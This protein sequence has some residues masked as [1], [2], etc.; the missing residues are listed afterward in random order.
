ME[1]R[2]L[3]GPLPKAKVDLLV[4]GVF[5]DPSGDA[6]FKLLSTASKRLLRSVVKEQ[7]FV[8]KSTQSV[9]ALTEKILPAKYVAILG[10]GNESRFKISDLRDHAARATAIG[11]RLGARSVA[12]ALPLLPEEDHALATQQA[13]EGGVLGCYKFDK[14][15]TRDL[16]PNPIKRFGVISAPKGGKLTRA[17]STALSAAIKRGEATARATCRA[18]DFVNEHAGYMTPT[19]I[20]EEAKSLAKEHGLKIKVLGRREC[21][22]LGMGMYLAVAQGSVEEPKFIHLT[23]S[24]P[25]K[26][27]SKI[28]I[29]GKGVMFDS[30]GYSLKPSSSMEDMKMDM[31]GAAAVIASMG[32]IASIGSPHEIHA[33]AACCENLISGSAFKLRDVLTAMDGSTVEINNTDAEGRLTLGDAITYARTKIEP[34]QILDFATLTGACMV[35]LGPHTAGVMSDTEDMVEE[36]LHAAGRSGEDMWRLPLTKKLKSQLKSPIAD[37][38]NT[39]ERWGGALTAGLF[40]QHFVKDSNW[41]H[42]D[43][44][45]PAMAA[46]SQG[47]IQRGATGFGV[48]TIVEY[49]TRE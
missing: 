44:A 22:K 27:K 10:F 11:Q 4:F 31:A 32:A 25:E 40:L 35:A 3:K 36:W 20:A 47:A 37:M 28:A 29:I 23:Y 16:E 39:G 14:Y 41:V 12:F 48:A 43:L 8:G 30:G 6:L 18:R 21:E 15:R 38:R 24:P 13:V 2:H 26:P 9:V 33:I 45:G 34:D 46:R 49:L 19:R 1:F 17:E 7:R 42:V 5:G